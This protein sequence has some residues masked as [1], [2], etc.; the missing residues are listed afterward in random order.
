MRPDRTPKISWPR[1]LALLSLGLAACN[2][3]WEVHDAEP[4]PVDHSAHVDARPVVRAAK[5]PP[6]ISG[7][8]L[9]VMDEG[10]TA[11]ASDPD[12]DLVHVVDL[13]QLEARHAIALEDGDEPG[14]VV[15]DDD[16][17]VHVV[18]RRGGVIVD[19][20]P[21]AGQVL[22]RRAVCA[23]P[24]GI[25]FDAQL[26]SLHVAC[27]GGDL[28]T[29]PVASG[30]PTRRVWL[31][32]D[33]RDVML[34]PDGL[35]V[36]RFR[37]AKVLL[38]DDDGA[39]VQVMGPPTL[40]KADFGELGEDT[41]DTQTMRPNTAW[42]TIA[43]PDGDWLRAHQVSTTK[44]LR[45][46]SGG[47]SEGGSG[48]GG[49][50]GGGYGGGGE[51]DSGCSGAVDSVLS[52]GDEDFMARSSGPL[53]GMVL[54]VDVAISDSGTWIAAAFAGRPSQT[55]EPRG[56]MMMA[57]SSFEDR[58]QP[59]CRQPEQALSERGQYVAVAFDPMGNLIALSR[60]P[61]MIVRVVPRYPELTDRV[62]LPGEPIIDT[63]HELFHRDA[64]QGIA[65]A[66]CHAEGGD[67]GRV[68][69]FEGFGSRHTP[70]LAV[71]L[72]GTEPFHWEGDLADMDALVADVHV[73]RMG[74]RSLSPERIDALQSWMFEIP[75]MRPRRAPTDAAA[76]RGATAFVEW[77][78]GDCHRGPA[79]DGG[80]GNVDLGLGLTLQVPALRGVAQHPPYMHDG[81]AQDLREAVIDMLARTRPQQGVP[82]EA[83]LLDMV[84]YLET[85]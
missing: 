75:V 44:P 66:T 53:D 64:G 17:M 40:H 9:T 12:R 6:P 68:W 5:T 59:E 43:T 8:T 39:V 74:G 11:I 27:A 55:S 15:A 25:V 65:C 81:R 85:L 19:I 26:D 32:P 49:G 78:C 48:S 30:G 76:Q 57:A 60:E 54:P 69:R 21:L 36:S 18:A 28:V 83:Q 56:V 80:V 10:R 23:N 51:I 67:D 73:G 14:R 16:G 72:R 7:G 77:G 71:G 1:R 31:G 13:E 20:D 33:L 3:G 4:R 41:G 24:R 58:Q 37:S 50:E 82:S 45:L 29:L 70:S 35:A 22:G 42:R 34:L 46:D 84:A 38:L 79:L 2:N 63:G 61:A 62:E 52:L 47:S